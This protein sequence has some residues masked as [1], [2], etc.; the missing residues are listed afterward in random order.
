MGFFGLFNFDKPGPGV[1]KDAPEKRGFFLFF[2]I[3]GRKFWRLVSLSLSYTLFAIP[4]FLVYFFCATV[5]QVLFSPLKDPAFILYMSIYCSLFLV[6]FLGA[7]PGSAGQAYVLRNFSREDHAWVWD[8]FISNTKE[9]FWKALGIF[10]LDIILFMGLLGAASLYF[11]NSAVM[12]LPPFMSLTLGFFALAVF[13]MYIM[14][15]FF[16]YPLLV[17]V[18]MRL[19]TALKTALQLTL[20]HLPGCILAFL[21]SLFAFAVFVMLFYFNIGF[22]VLFACLGFSVIAF[23]YT[24]YGTSV[25]DAELRQNNKL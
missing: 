25:M 16:L 5:L 24:Y 11:I 4:A 3:L 18:D 13:W 21:G 17:T 10:I 9:N 23:V 22:I 15:H 7:G 1:D 14:M 6:S 8:D 20:S 2:D 19:G 12:P